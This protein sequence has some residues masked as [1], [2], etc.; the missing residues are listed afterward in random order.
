LG[1]YSLEMSATISPSDFI[2]TLEE[3]RRSEIAKIDALIRETMPD[4]KPVL[5]GNMLGYGP[6]RYRY[7]SGREGDMCDIS[8]CSKKNHISLHV[9]G[10]DKFKSRLPKADIGVACVRF[11]K[12]DDLDID[13]V[14]D[15]LRQAPDIRAIIEK[16]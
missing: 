8:L 6:F 7:S 5:V 3:P 2:A 11:K 9:F 15:L 1:R 10:A 14:I 12:L 4:L 16:K 13:A